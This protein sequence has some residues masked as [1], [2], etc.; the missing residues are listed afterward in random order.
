ELELRQGGTAQRLDDGVEQAFG[1]E[2]GR[3][4]TSDA[5]GCHDGVAAHNDDHTPAYAKL[6]LEGV[7]YTGYRAG[8]QNSVVFG[9]APTCV[10]IAGFNGDVVDLIAL[11]VLRAMGGNAAIDFDA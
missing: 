3:A 10:C 4:G 8:K 9:S 11:Q 2:A 1:F 6:V 7:G 5:H